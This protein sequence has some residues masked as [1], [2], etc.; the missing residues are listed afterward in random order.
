MVHDTLC[1][2]SGCTGCPYGYRPVSPIDA[3]AE[4]AELDRMFSASK[5]RRDRVNG[6]RSVTLVVIVAAVAIVLLAPETAF[7]MGLLVLSVSALNG[8]ATVAT[9]FSNSDA[10]WALRV[11]SVAAVLVTGCVALM[12]LDVLW[13]YT[14]AATGAGG[15]AGGAT[16]DRLGWRSNR[17]GGVHGAGPRLAVHRGGLEHETAGQMTASRR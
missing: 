17:V 5:L 2:I 9:T 7:R 11:S 15:P 6:V 4:A 16:A 13:P 14:L 8:L 1:Q 3:K 10:G 12:V